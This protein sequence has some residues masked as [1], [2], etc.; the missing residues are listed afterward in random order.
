M[1]EFQYFDGCPN[2]TETLNNLNTLVEEGF[3]TRG[4]INVLEIKD[5][6]DAKTMN[7][8]GSPTILVDGIDIYS[9]RKP[10]SYAYSCRLYVI[11]DVQTGILPKDY[12]KSQVTKF[13]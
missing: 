12:I 5:L 13:K 4:E 6:E 1:V 2:A 3:L 7:F 8:Q 9:E 10:V 11:N